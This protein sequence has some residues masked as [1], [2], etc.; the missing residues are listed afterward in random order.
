MQETAT[1]KN[2][3][4]NNNKKNNNNSKNAQKKQNQQAKTKKKP[5]NIQISRFSKLQIFFNVLKRYKSIPKDVYRS[6]HIKMNCYRS[7]I[8][9]WA[10]PGNRDYYIK[11]VNAKFFLK[12]LSKNVD[13]VN[14]FIHRIVAWQEK[15]LSTMQEITAKCFLEDKILH[16]YVILA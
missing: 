2:N 13:I 3:N 10:E 5:Q 9:K 14:T 11:D 12:S 7:K 16:R 6:L 1:T 15:K 8:L 4:R